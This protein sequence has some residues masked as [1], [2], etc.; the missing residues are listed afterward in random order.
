MPRVLITGVNGFI[1]QYLLQYRPP[2]ATVTGTLNPAGATAHSFHAGCH[3]IP[4]DLTKPVAHQL[5]NL[6][7]DVVIHLAAISGLGDCQHHPE[8]AQRVNHQATAELAAW[9]AQNQIRLI[10][11]STDIVFGGRAAPYSEED[12][13]NPVNVYG[14]T[15]WQGEQA[16]R[17][18]CPDAAIVRLPLVLGR[19]LGGRSNFVDWFLMHLNQNKTIKLFIDEI[20]TPVSVH[21]VAKALWQIALSDETGI[22]HLAGNEALNR[23]ELGKLFCRTLGR[24]EQLLTQT[25]LDSFSAYP[26]PKDVS[27]ISTRTLNGSPLRLPS[28]REKT[29]EILGLTNPR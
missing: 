25:T 20:R 2:D 8:L 17:E 22:F 6:Q 26:R 10:Y 15:K 23:W 21:D 18:T 1:G 28:I 7:A 13:P 11:T 24:G 29:A 19:G 3:T 27:L 12:R 9:C 4:L 14:K 5:T 16:V